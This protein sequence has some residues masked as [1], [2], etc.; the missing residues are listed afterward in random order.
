MV[1]DDVLKLY[2]LVGFLILLAFIAFTTW[3]IKR[4]VKMAIEETVC[5]TKFREQ[6]RNDITF[7]II[8]A[9]RQQNERNSES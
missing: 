5:N 8:C 4:S 6:I 1:V 2:F 3:L 7:A 9:N